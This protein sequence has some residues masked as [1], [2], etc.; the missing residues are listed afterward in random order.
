M[1]VGRVFIME[2][3]NDVVVISENNPM[4][5]NA[6]KKKKLL[7]TKKKLYLDSSLENSTN[8]N[9]ENKLSHQTYPKRLLF[10]YFYVLNPIFLFFVWLML[11]PISQSHTY[12]LHSVSFGVY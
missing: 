8:T 2:G 12:T 10:F 1:C 11:N 9:F 4:K 6:K 5:T 3:N 7:K